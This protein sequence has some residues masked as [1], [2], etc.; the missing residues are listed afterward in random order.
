[1]LLEWQTTARQNTKRIQVWPHQHKLVRV[2]PVDKQ[3]QSAAA[4]G[5][6]IASSALGAQIVQRCCSASKGDMKL[7]RV[8]GDDSAPHSRGK[9]LAGRTPD[10]CVGWSP[11]MDEDGTTIISTS[12]KNKNDPSDAPLQDVPHEFTR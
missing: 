11:G 6:G 2:S 1:M 4:L 9:D 12:A 8:G 10:G 3:K 7:T 5:H